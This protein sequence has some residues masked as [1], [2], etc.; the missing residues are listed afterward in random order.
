MD[1]AEAHQIQGE[2]ESLRA[3]N[4]VPDLAPTL[5]ASGKLLGDDGYFFLSEYKEMNGSVDEDE[6]ARLLAELHDP[7]KRE[8]GRRF[9]FHVTTFCGETAQDN[10]WEDSWEVFFSRRRIHF[11]GRRIFENTGDEALLGW[12][13]KTCNIVIPFLLGGLDFDPVLIHG[14]LWAGNVGSDLQ[15]GCPV[16]FDP[17]SVYAHNELGIMRLFGGFS[18]KFF[19]AY[20]QLR[21]RMEPY[22][23]QRQELYKYGIAHVNILL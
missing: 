5:Y 10:I 2:A 6:F 9:G 16:I 4:T 12:V 3:L 7:G 20:H 18:S 11:L 21:P 17:S 13:E 8:V 22:Y 1:P 23:E 14:D 15:T 19:E